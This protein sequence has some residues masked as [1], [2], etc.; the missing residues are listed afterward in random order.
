MGGKQPLLSI[1]AARAQILEMLLPI[2]AQETVDLKSASG[3]ILAAEITSPF[4]FPPYDNSAMDGY[5]VRGADLPNSG[6]TRLKVIGES[7]AG[8]PF[9]GKTVEM[10][11]TVRIMTGAKMPAGAD[12]VIMQEKVIREGDEAILSADGKHKSGE[13]VRLTGEGM[14]KGDTALVSGQLL[15]AAELGELASLG[16]G[17]AQVVRKVKVAM[18]STGDELRPLGEPL[19]EGQIYDSNRYAIWGMLQSPEIEIIDLGLIPDDRAKIEAAFQ[20]A[21]RQADVVITS[22]GVSVGEADFVKETLVKLGKINFWKINMKP[23]KPLAFGQ[24]ENAWFFGLPGNPVSAMVTFM[25]FVRPALRRLSGLEAVTPLRLRLRCL[26]TLKKR[27][28]RAEFQ[29]G[30]MEQVESGEWVVRSTGAQ[31]SHL[32][33][34]MSEA[35]CFIFL[36]TESAGIAADDTVE[37]EPFID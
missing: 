13:N 31:G 11:E 26:D 20:E 10:G 19:K 30:K 22:G 14:K 28:G 15:N 16:Y 24:V 3:R 35:D 7:F 9:D 2:S 21:A 1:D 18:F 4:D 17:A 8:H 33:H 12:T 27:S 36:D 23:G 32:L 25:Q 34:S 6:E 37:V 5:A 29:R